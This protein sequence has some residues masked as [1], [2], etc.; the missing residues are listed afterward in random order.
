MGRPEAVSYSGPTYI[1]IRSGKHSS[2]TANS[3]AQD[4]DPLLSLAPFYNFMKNGDGEFKPV[5]IIS[6]DGGPDEN[7]RYR[8]VIAHAI[9]MKKICSGRN[10]NC[11]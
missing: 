3:Q 5:L 4:L 10:I 11:D 8:K 6:S 9:E 2:S 1:V 7:P